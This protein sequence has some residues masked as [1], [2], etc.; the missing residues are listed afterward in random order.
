MEAWRAIFLTVLALPATAAD[1][2]REVPERFQGAWCSEPLPKQEDPGESDIRIDS[3]QISYYRDAGEILAVA[4]AEDQL[5]LI[6]QLTVGGRAS[7][8][9][10]EF[11][12]SGDGKR[13]TSLRTDGQLQTRVR[14]HF[15]PAAPPNNSFKPKPLRGSA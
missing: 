12:L 11:E 5:A 15:S 13:L 6:V 14:C 9:T 3:R 1:T 8:A 7:L 10:H 2:A 4:V